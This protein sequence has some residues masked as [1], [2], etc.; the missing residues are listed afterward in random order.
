MPKGCRSIIEESGPD[1][2][3]KGWW[4]CRTTQCPFHLLD[5]ERLLSGLWA[6][7]STVEEKSNCKGF[8]KFPRYVWNSPHGYGIAFPRFGR[9]FPM[10]Q[11]TFPRFSA[12]FPVDWVS[13]PGFPAVFPHFLASPCGF[14]A[15]L[16]TYAAIFQ[17][18]QKT[19]PRSSPVTCTQF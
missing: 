6:C 18:K 11:A 1:I 14:T 4:A 9:V 8:H 10:D 16:F 7:R 3:K 5:P 13:F 2:S 17:K 19:G 15:F 12:V